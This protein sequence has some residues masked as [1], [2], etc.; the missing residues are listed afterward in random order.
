MVGA[1]DLAL[2]HNLQTSFWPTRR[3][4]QGEARAI[5]PG[6]KQIGREADHS[7]PLRADIK[8]EWSSVCLHGVQRENITSVQ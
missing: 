7:P 2:L 8:N 5:S 6:V 3:T 1:I 4:I